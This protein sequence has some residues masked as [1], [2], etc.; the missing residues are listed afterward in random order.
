MEN[1]NEKGKIKRQFI[2]KQK[3]KKIYSNS[4]IAFPSF[5]SSLRLQEPS[6]PITVHNIHTIRRR[7]KKRRE[8]IGLPK[9]GDD[10]KVLFCYQNFENDYRN[11]IEKDLKNKKLYSIIRIAGPPKKR[12]E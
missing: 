10:N 1:K 4:V 3:S 9:G 12:K 2:N 6:F 5:S 11:K 8:E 7:K